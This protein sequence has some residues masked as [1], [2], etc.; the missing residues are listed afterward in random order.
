MTMNDG[1]LIEG[2]KYEASGRIWEVDSGKESICELVVCV[3]QRR[4]RPHRPCLA[5]R[6][7]GGSGIS[8]EG[9][10]S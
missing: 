4:P 7:L 6:W 1:L 2:Y 9:F 3:V 10:L 8:V 5:L